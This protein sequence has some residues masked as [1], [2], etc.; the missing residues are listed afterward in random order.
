MVTGMQALPAKWGSPG[1]F[2]L[3]LSRAGHYSHVPAGPHTS[4]AGAA[5]AAVRS[6]CHAGAAAG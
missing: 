2:K 6:C 1:D 4:A 3:F 5:G